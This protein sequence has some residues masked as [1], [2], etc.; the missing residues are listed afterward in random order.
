[1]SPIGA[2]RAAKPWM[3]I[4]DCLAPVAANTARMAKADGFDG[5][6]RYVETLTEGEIQGI[7]AAG[8]A[9]VPL[10]EGVTGMELTAALGK[11][12]EE[13]RVE[14]LVEF[15]CPGGVSFWTDHEDPKVGSDSVGYLT[16]RANVKIGAGFRAGLYGGMPMD[17][18]G[19]QLYRL[20]FTGYWRGGGA[21]PEPT[22]GW[23]IYQAPPLNQMMSWGQ[24]VD[25]NFTMGDYKGRYPVLWYPE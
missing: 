9:L 14:K 8:L 15:G 6:A 2:A 12:I 18:T 5:V 4:F 17:L 11:S 20:P 25:V 3:R 21:V 16:A 13:A 23:Q 19:I 7:F 1:M 10:S 24:L 22:C